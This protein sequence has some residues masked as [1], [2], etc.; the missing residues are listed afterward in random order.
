MEIYCCIKVSIKYFV[1]EINRILVPIGYVIVY[2]KDV[3][4][5]IAI[6]EDLEA[7]PVNQIMLKKNPDILKTIKMVRL[8]VLSLLY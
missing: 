1:F 3:D 5:C 2:L 6:M 4:K 8:R 7:L